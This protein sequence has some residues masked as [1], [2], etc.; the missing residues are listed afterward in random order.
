MHTYVVHLRPG[1]NLETT[2]AGLAVHAPAL[3]DYFRSA[4]TEYGPVFAP[5]ADLL[6]VFDAAD[7]EGVEDLLK[8][9]RRLREPDADMVLIERRD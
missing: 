1:P 8:A 7:G 6:Q 2:G 9:I 4:R 5:A 3:A